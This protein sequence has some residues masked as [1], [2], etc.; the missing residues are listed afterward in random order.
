MGSSRNL[1][2][3]FPVVARRLV[4]KNHD[5]LVLTV[6]IA[7][8]LNLLDCVKSTPISLSQQFTFALPS[9]LSGLNC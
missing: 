7:N 3:V 2:E 4:L 5:K 6:T 9:C 1:C 8:G